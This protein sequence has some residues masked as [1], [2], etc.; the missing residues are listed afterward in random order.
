M[1][2]IFSPCLAI[3]EL[4]HLAISGCDTVELA[5]QYGTPLYVMSEDEIRRVCRNYVESFQKFYNGNGRPIYASKA[6]C[7]KEMC[8]I[9]FSEGLDLEVVSGGELYTALEAGIPGKNI[10]FQGNNKTLAELEM[11][12]DNHVGD[13]VVDNL[14]ELDKLEKIVERKG[15]I[16]HITLRVKPGIDAHTHEFIRTGQID[17]KFGL[18]LASGEAFAAAS[19]A[20]K[21]PGVKLVGLHCHIGSQI[22]EK[23][24]FVHAAEVMLGLYDQIIRE[25][26]VE[27]EILNLGGGFGIHYTEK[28][29]FIPY[30][31]YM[32]AVSQKIH[33]KC[34]ELELQLPKIFIEPGRS[35]VG[36]A[37]ITLYTVGNIREIPQIRNYVAIDG[38]MFEN[39]RYALY[40]SDYTCMIANK[41]DKPADYLATVAG[42]CCES[43]DLIQEHTAIQRPEENDILAVLS[44]GAY[45][46]SM[47]SN[48][49]RNPKPACIMVSQGESRVV[50]RGESYQDLLKN[51]V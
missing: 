29:D 9:A 10:H 47:A 31:E 5:H 34:T 38:G 45:N 17:S 41:V 16:V 49:N 32:E 42:K 4:G 1:V 19:R 51:D 8:R 2:H 21:I 39:P 6:F 18:D 43:G 26:G 22:M 20:V 44:T 37:G 28:D 23:E 50:I 27:L 11:A 36:E 15:E 25:L 14:S 24:P 35:V 33:E 7:C 40:Q 30:M 12:V 13:I 48:Y 46:Y 3:N